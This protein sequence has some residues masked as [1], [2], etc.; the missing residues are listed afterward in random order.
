MVSNYIALLGGV[1]AVS[2]MLLLVYWNLKF[3]GGKM[4]GIEMKKIPK[5][6]SSTSVELGTEL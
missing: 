5:T 6:S 1:F 2:R 3:F 4:F